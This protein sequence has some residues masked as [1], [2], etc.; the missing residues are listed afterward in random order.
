MASRREL[1]GTMATLW[2]ARAL[3]AAEAAPRSDDLRERLRKLDRASR[4]LAARSIQPLEWQQAAEEVCRGID[5]DALCKAADFDRLVRR[6]PLLER[7]TSAEVTALLPGQA[8]TPKIFAMGRGRA[9]IPHGHRNMVSQ[10]LVLQG[11]MHGR[12]YQRVRDE[13]ENLI[14]R[15]T[16]DRTFR[17]GDF[18]SI[19]DQRDNVHWFVTTSER[20]Y[21]LDCIVDALDPAR[22]Y[23]FGIDFIDPDRAIAAGDG[24]LRVPRLELDE[25]LGRYG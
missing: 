7:G 3:Q 10:H 6:L 17:R 21:T 19:S 9:I 14:V 24:M 12:H 13:P 18:S 15:P 4:A 5:V 16:I 1:L 22:G 2:L 8:F 23:R 11:E 20:A 25:C